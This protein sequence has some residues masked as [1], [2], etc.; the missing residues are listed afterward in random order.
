MRLGTAG[1]QHELLTYC[2]G[3]H[4]ERFGVI[5]FASGGDVTPE[6]KRAAAEVDEAQ[7]HPLCRT[8]KGEAV[9]TGQEYAEVFVGPQGLWR[10]KHGPEYRYVALREGPSLT[11]DG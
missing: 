1:Y 7:W 8:A 5:E 6:F 10:R 11:H 9:A 4:K 3:G 2:A